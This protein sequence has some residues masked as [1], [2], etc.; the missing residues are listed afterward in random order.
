[1]MLADRYRLDA[2][3]GHGGMG[4]VWQAWD[5]R[6]SRPVAVKLL[7]D[8]AVGDDA[9]TAGFRREARTAALITHPRVVAVYDFGVS[10]R[11]C[12]LVMEYVQ[13][14]S[15]ADELRRGGPLPPSRVASVAAGAAEGLAA[16]HRQGVVHRDV[17]PANLLVAGDGTVKVADFGIARR[18]S[19]DTTAGT[20][21]GEGITGTCLYLAPEAALGER[22]G[23]AGDV[24]SLGCALYELLTGRPPFVA[25]HPLAV[26][27]LHVE[28]EPTAPRLLRPQVPAELDAY[29]LRMLA[30]DPEQRPTA[31]EAAQWFAQAGLADATGGAEEFGSGER[32]AVLP[33]VT[34]AAGTALLAPSGPPAPAG[35]ARPAARRRMALAGAAVTAGV[36]TAAALA[37][38][39]P[40]TGGDHHPAPAVVGP[41][42]VAG[43][44]GSVHRP[45]AATPGA[46][47][48]TL[49]APADL[50]SDD[51]AGHASVH[52]KPGR[53]PHGTAGG[54]TAPATPAPTH[55]GTQSPP[56]SPS[57]SPSSPQPTPTT[58][59]PSPSDSG[60]S[61]AQGHG[62]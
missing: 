45:G 44:G 13:G 52:G 27:C 46:S 48:G 42:S 9:L 37:F 33:V 35:P 18:A 58:P 32:T 57:P 10:Q 22:A 56:S 20:A 40:W 41:R 51:G 49:A 6:L 19:A 16:A 62:A 14:D 53:R 30:K 21:P 4:E 29:L 24:Y 59:S 2:L 50:D 55:G 23:T 8:A 36:L 15:L 3:L 7:A 11:R 28:S 38:G 54:A 34:P 60:G 39:T 26:L 17:K 12:F 43:G 25:E 31:Q 5:T 1:M 61:P 47:A